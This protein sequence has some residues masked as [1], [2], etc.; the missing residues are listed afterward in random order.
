MN[1]TFVTSDENPKA[2]II[3]AGDKNLRMI[4]AEML[5]RA[6]GE[7]AKTPDQKE[8]GPGG[9]IVLSEAP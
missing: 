8:A 4:L 7:T 5:K 2:T 1:I 9:S 6:T 3:Y